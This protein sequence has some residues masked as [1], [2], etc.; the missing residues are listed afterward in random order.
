[1]ATNNAEGLNF[2]VVTTGNPVVDARPVCA[3]RKLTLA[4]V[5]QQVES[6]EI[7]DELKRELIRSASV[8][9]ENAL[10]HWIRNINKHM[11]AARRSLRRRSPS[12]DLAKAEQNLGDTE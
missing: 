10:E 1:M 3:L 12:E 5:V 8:Y 7:E 6:M 11:S 4:K 2:K 9:P